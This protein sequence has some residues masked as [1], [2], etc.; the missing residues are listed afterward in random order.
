MLHRTKGSSMATPGSDA[1]TWF[2]VP[3]PFL[4]PTLRALRLG[5]T[6]LDALFYDV[7]RMVTDLFLT[8]GASFTQ[9]VFSFK[10][11]PA[12]ATE[13]VSLALIVGLLGGIF[14]SIRAARMPILAGLYGR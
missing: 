12:L 4:E 13:G 9:V 3:R 1:F 5:N 14:P 2:E 6:A 11:T 7:S 8:L 10:L